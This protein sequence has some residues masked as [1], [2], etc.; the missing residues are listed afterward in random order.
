[1]I[2]WGWTLTRTIQAIE[3]AGHGVEVKINGHNYFFGL[4]EFTDANS[5]LA[6]IEARLNPDTEA[7][8]QINARVASLRTEIVGAVV[9][10]RL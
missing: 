6:L 2:V 3:R 10:D 4:D 1:M 5:L 9:N 8:S 7:E